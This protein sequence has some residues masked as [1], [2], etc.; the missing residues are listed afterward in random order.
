MQKLVVMVGVQ[1]ANNVVQ[2][3]GSCFALPKAGYFVTCRHV[4]GDIIEH[5]VL[6]SSMDS[7]N[8]NGYQDTS[9]KQC[10]VVQV[11]TIED[12]N[13]LCDLVIL[14]ADVVVNDLCPISSL[15]NVQV[16]DE[17]EVI[18]YPHCVNDWQ[19][20]ILTIQKTM[21][22]AKILRE[23]QG[24]KYKYAI[25]NIQTR[26]GQS[27]SMVFSTRLQKVIGILVGGYAPSSGISIGGI[28][29]QELNQ[30][31]FC[32]SSQYITEMFEE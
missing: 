15:D 11:Q 3:L 13:P 29:P 21:V 16:G 5:L 18:G 12:V 7:S 26:P 4:I 31:S 1:D 19:M 32:L 9:I 8:I 30:T 17:V 10:R 14:K 6:V 24:I 22:G 28:N 23:S 2:L 25:L 27:G 20:H